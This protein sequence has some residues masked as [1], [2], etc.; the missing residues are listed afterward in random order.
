MNQNF[1]NLTNQIKTILEET[2]FLNGKT[3]LWANDMNLL[4]N[5]PELDSMAVMNVV[6][7]LEK[8]F[9]FFMEDD[10]INADVFTS[11]NTLTDYIFQ[12]LESKTLVN[13]N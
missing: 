12:K 9:D 1:I 2:L 6:A 11:I 13:A 3:K 4:G 7:G 5:V 8:Y 10:E